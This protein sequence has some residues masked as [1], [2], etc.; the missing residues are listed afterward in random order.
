ML[1]LARTFFNIVSLSTCV[2]N[3]LPIEFQMPEGELSFGN[4]Q[5]FQIIVLIIVSII[6]LIVCQIHNWKL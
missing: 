1:K 2:N 4:N 5:N 3:N 6:F